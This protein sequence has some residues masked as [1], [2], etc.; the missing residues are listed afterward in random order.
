MVY[1]IPA[2]TPQTIEP[3]A[4]PADQL[5]RAR[6]EFVRV[7]GA[8]PQLSTTQLANDLSTPG[9]PRARAAYLAICLGE[10]E[11][12]K[13]ASP[14]VWSAAI[15]ELQEKHPAVVRNLFKSPEPAGDQLRR[16]AQFAG[17]KPPADK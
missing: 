9:I 15:T 4:T 17:L 1:R 7:P 12:L 2:E 6:K 8:T 13:A 10:S 3:L 14:E 5:A 11:K 16:N